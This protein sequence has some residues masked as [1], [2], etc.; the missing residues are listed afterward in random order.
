[1]H[2]I[3]ITISADGR[4]TIA[5]TIHDKGNV[6]ATLTTVLVQETARMHNVSVQEASQLLVIP[7]NIG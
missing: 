3:E 2:T 1:M 6:M 7:Y 4:Y 5:S